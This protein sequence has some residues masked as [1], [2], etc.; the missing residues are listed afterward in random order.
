MVMSTAS[1]SAQIVPNECTVH[2]QGS[3]HEEAG[4]EKMEAYFPESDLNDLPKSLEPEEKD[5]AGAAEDYLAVK[6]RVP[7]RK[8]MLNMDLRLSER[9]LSCG[10]SVFE[11]CLVKV[12]D[13]KS[14][15][16]LGKII[17]QRGGKFN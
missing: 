7:A 16:A 15:L 5:I 2:I 9:S 13:E 1:L 3:F 17:E 6:S 10:G 8:Y 14:D 12:G 11:N 4:Q